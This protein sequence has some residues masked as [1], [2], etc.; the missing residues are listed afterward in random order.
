MRKIERNLQGAGAGQLFEGHPEIHFE[1]ELFVVLEVD[2]KSKVTEAGELLAE[3]PDILARRPGMDDL[4]RASI[5]ENAGPIAVYLV[6]ALHGVILRSQGSA[7]V[8]AIGNRYGR[9]VAES[10][11]LVREIVHVHGAV[12]A[13]IVVEREKNV[14]HLRPDRRL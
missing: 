13:E 6:E 9:G 7:V 3:K 2:K 8:W 1:D 10:G 11:E 5:R 4:R 14:A 12:G